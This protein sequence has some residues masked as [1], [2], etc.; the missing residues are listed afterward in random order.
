MDWKGYIEAFYEQDAARQARLW[1]D[2]TPDQQSAFRLAYE[3]G[4]P[5]VP[6]PDRLGETAKDELDD[7]IRTGNR[8]MEG[9][10]HRMLWGSTKKGHEYTAWRLACIGVLRDL[11]PQAEHLLSTVENKRHETYYKHSVQQILGAMI[12]ARSIKGQVETP[13]HRRVLAEPQ[14]SVF[15]VH[16]HD[17]FV[18][19]QAARLLEQ[20]GLTPIVLFEETSR[21]R[22]IIEKLEQHAAC[23]AALVL[24]T[25]DDVGAPASRS[26]N[27]LPRARQNV[28]LELGYFL[29]A[30]GRDRVVV[31][32]SDGVELPSD[33][34]GVEYIRFD[35]EGAW[36]L[37]IARELGAAGL[38]VDLNKLH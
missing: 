34:T 36:K 22:T 6:P 3:G 11:G 37:R 31:L 1:S 5:T 12:A 16:G 23:S 27:L 17:H 14:G 26:D 2:L 15:V 29:G 7:L 38:E 13:S 4:D 20:L 19:Q 24:L 25:P 9:D 32:Y 35:A 8:L 18:L 33:Y 10:L 30:L 21:G 28:V